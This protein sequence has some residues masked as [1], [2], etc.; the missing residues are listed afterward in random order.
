MLVK[1]QSLAS[2]FFFS[3]DLEARMGSSS[4][5]RFFHVCQIERKEKAESLASE[6]SEK[7][8]GLDW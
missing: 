5:S 6:T 1:K 7:R 3:L 4:D 2:C 8:E